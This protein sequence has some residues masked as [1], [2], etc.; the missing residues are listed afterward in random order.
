MSIS[1]TLYVETDSSLREILAQFFCGIGI[2]ADL[3]R[4]RKDRVLEFAQG[5]GFS[6]DAVRITGPVSYT[7][8]LEQ[9]LGFTPT[10]KLMMF[11]DRY[12]SLEAARSRLMQA[13]LYLVYNTPWN[14]ALRFQCEKTVL[15]RR[16]GQL[17]LSN[18]PDVWTPQRLKIA[19]SSY[20]VAELNQQPDV[21]FV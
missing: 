9:I 19:G 12:G 13:T 6:V 11:Y 1:E 20:T 18:R 2:Q 15:L 14:L 4:E 8:Y 3:E 16:D 17:L 7:E 5:P 21:I 10:A